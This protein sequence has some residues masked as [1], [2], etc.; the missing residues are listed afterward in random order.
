MSLFMDYQ[1][2]FLSSTLLFR[3]GI[4][5]NDLWL[6]RRGWRERERE[7][8]S[9][10]LFVCHIERWPVCPSTYF[11]AHFEVLNTAKTFKRT[12]SKF[13]AHLRRFFPLF[14]KQTYMLNTSNV[15]A[16][17]QLLP[18]CLSLLS[19]SVFISCYGDGEGG[20]ALHTD[21]P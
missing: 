19:N 10:Y 6:V 15:P 13:Y 4:N 21:T 9:F 11:Y 1:S 8:F 5:F 3:G 14:L 16:F 17:E 7:T 2:A 12:Q 20:D 18:N